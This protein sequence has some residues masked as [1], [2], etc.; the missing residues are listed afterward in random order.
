MH[1]RMRIEGNGREV[2]REIGGYG[3][4]DLESRCE[5]ERGERRDERAIHNGVILEMKSMNLNHLITSYSYRR[6]EKKRL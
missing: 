2:F 5:E 4:R 1:A 6:R 3:G